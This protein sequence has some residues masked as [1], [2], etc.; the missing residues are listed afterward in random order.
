MFQSTPANFT[1]GDAFEDGHEVVRVRGF[2]PRPPISQRATPLEVVEPAHDRLF[3]STPANFTAG[4]AIVSYRPPSSRAFQSTPANF[5]AGDMRQVMTSCSSDCFNPR[6]PISQRA[7]EGLRAVERAFLRFNPRPP[8]SQRA[9]HR[10]CGFSTSNCSFQSTPANFT[11]GDLEELREEL[12]ELE[13]SIH[14]RQFHSGRHLCTAVLRL[15]RHVS[16]HARQFH[17]GRRAR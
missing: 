14:A 15:T 16:I 3:Q 2:N 11:A 17:S 12:A 9:T 1:A 4:D 10:I 13:V 6:P 8:I 7:T 5:T